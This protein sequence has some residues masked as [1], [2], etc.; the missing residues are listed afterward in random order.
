MKQ[1]QLGQKY[2]FKK[3]EILA[4][5]DVNNIPKFPEISVKN[6]WQEIKN[7]NYA[8]KYFPDLPKNTLPDRAYFFP[9]KII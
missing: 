7:D 1:V 9:V 3:D 8:S 6:I 5:P 2:L 4:C